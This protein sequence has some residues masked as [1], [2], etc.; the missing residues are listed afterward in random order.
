MAHIMWSSILLHHPGRPEGM[1]RI[2]DPIP[3]VW[4]NKQWNP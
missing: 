1:E 3:G 4:Q 2:S